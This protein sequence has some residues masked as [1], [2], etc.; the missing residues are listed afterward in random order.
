MTFQ[1]EIELIS[2]FPDS[3]EKGET[4]HIY[5]Q[6]GWKYLNKVLTELNIWKEDIHFKEYLPL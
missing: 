2:C 6:N 5:R 1:T 4:S 3:G